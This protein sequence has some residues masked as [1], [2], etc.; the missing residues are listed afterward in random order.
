MKS[1]RDIRLVDKARLASRQRKIEF[2]TGQRVGLAIISL[3]MAIYALSLVYPFIFLLLNSFRNEYD[4]I[5]YPTSFPT[6]WTLS[7][8]IAVFK[9]YNMGEMFFNSVTL[10]LGETIASMFFTC[11]AAYVLAKFK[12]PG[13]G[14]IY[15]VVLVSGMLPT[16]ASLPST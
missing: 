11:C 8:Y 7:N 16:I 15:S 4:Y 10:S 3:A 5:M 12:F 14:F 2:S 6:E 13:N 1:K 9:E